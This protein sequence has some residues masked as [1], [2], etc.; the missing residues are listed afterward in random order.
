MLA[1]LQAVKTTQETGLGEE[2]S[3]ALDLRADELLRRELIEKS[4]G[5]FRYG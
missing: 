5:D 2:L 4:A 3:E 1:A